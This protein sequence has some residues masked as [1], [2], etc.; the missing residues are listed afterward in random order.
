M[1]GQQSNILDRILENKRVEV[2]QAK[3][4]VPLDDLK[5]AVH[6]LPRPRNF[7]AA[8]AAKPTRGI[9]VIAEIKKRSPSA[10]LIREDFDPCADCPDLPRQRRQR[11]VGPDGQELL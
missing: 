11:A 7:Y 4:R 8:I 5:R 10:G 9:H 6:D 2:E 1:S 3:A